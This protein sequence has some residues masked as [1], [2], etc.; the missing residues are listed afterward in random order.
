MGIKTYKY[1]LN[2]TKCNVMAKIKRKIDDNEEA[3][4]IKHVL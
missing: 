1:I 3:L 2:V 4:I